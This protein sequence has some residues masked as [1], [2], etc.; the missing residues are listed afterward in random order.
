MSGEGVGWVGGKVSELSVIVE[1]GLVGGRQWSMC[2]VE[3]SW[4]FVHVP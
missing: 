3:G 2:Y 4:F 1:E